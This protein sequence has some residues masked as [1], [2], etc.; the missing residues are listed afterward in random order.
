VVQETRLYDSDKDETRSMRSK[1]EANDYRYFPDPDLLPVQIDEAYI[2]A[3]RATL[4]ELPDE[5]AARFAR[6]LGLSA[7]DAGVLSASRE[8]GAY[9]EAVAA[10]IGATPASHAHAKLAANWV[11][12][13]LSS[14]L[15]R[16]NVEVKESRVSPEQLSGLLAR[17][18]D[19]TISGKIAKEVFEA[20]WS[21]GKSADAIIEA[22]GLKQITD[23]GAIE[24]VIDAVIA[25]NPKQLADYRSGKDKLFGFFVG[26]VMKATEGKA[27]PAQLN[28]LL[29]RKLGGGA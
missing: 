12:G 3:V 1:E 5:K 21:E 28:E 13:E 4:P 17:I 6:D 9:F 29:K 16:D 10:P 20:M 23:S 15:N 14:A 26:Q 7:Y 24:G 22:K 2:D 8:L 27:N 25:A 11:M 19:Q 18:V